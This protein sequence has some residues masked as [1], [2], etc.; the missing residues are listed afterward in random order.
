[1]SNT[2]NIFRLP[3]FDI[4][5]SEYPLPIAVLNYLYHPALIAVERALVWGRAVFKT[6]YRVHFPIGLA[7]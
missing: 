1:M 5:T 3:R 2:G 4:T 7:L 6:K